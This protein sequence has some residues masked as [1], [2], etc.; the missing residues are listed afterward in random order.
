MAD[1]DIKQLE[2]EAATMA[3]FYLSELESL[4]VVFDEKQNSHF[5][6]QVENIYLKGAVRGTQLSNSWRGE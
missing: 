4:G 3:N 2:R 6:L 5:K 1:K